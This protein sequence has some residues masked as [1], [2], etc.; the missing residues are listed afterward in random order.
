MMVLLPTLSIYQL[1]ILGKKR[2]KKKSL[3]CSL[4]HKRTVSYFR[5][6][7][8]IDRFTATATATVCV[9]VRVRVCVINLFIVGLV[10]GY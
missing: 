8:C 2:K 3:I 10:V 4:L 6:L 7:L 5:L 1:V 9:C